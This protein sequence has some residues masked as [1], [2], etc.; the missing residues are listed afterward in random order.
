MMLKTFIPI[1]DIFDNTRFNIEKN[2]D[3]KQENFLFN[4]RNSECDF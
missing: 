4:I 1:F 2:E 3:G